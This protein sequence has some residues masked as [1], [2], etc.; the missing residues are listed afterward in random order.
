MNKMVS[1]IV[2][3]YNAERYLKKCVN[4]LLQ[5]TYQDLEIIL[6]DDGS[7]DSSP[8]MCDQFAMQDSR[9]K[10]IHQKNMRIGATR[11]RG[12]DASSG[13][14]ITF[15]DSDDY[16]NPT[17]Y[18]EAIQLIKK[19]N[20]D[21]VQWDFTFVPEADCK[22]V[23]N[24]RPL[25][26]YTELVL[27]KKEALQTL[28]GVKNDDKRFNH[29]W[30]DSH[31]VWTKFCKRKVFEGV[32]FPVGKEYEDEMIVHKLLNNSTRT[33]FINRRFSNYLL[34]NN[35]TVHT[36]SLRGK[37]DKV[38]A[39]MDRY[40]LIK[41]IGDTGLISGMVRDCVII[42]SNLYL[43]AHAASDVEMKKSLCQY[44]KKILLESKNY[45]QKNVWLTAELLKYCPVLF[46][47][48]YRLY[49]KIR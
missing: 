18:E 8:T 35:S 3:V 31:C 1:V 22:A 39:Y 44:N 7:T 47:V 6:V 38:D 28:I 27:S 34:R 19:Y 17:A 37:F 41:K 29:L 48:V 42:I 16:L 45:M 30:T 11:N 12:L 49:R 13:D 46:L 2:P 40:E 43:D 9:V 21:M 33:V 36:M 5:Q 20:A 4:S 15:I 32:R 10:V 23:M 14:Y 26:E 25:A 24:N